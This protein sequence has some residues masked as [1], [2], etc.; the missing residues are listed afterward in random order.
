VAA[1]NFHSFKFKGDGF[2]KRSDGT[3]YD[4]DPLSNTVHRVV[5]VRPEQETRL[6]RLGAI[7]LT[8]L[9][10]LAAIAALWVLFRGA[11]DPAGAGR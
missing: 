8:A 9:F 10:S 11:D 1:G 5:L 7:A 4:F 6:F 3:H 2:P